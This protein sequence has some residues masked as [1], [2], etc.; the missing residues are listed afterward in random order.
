LDWK[1]IITQEVMDEVYFIL[2]S[3]LCNLYVCTIVQ[4]YL[5]AMYLSKMGWLNEKGIMVTVKVGFL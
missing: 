2:Y 4:R 3:P 1:G 5:M